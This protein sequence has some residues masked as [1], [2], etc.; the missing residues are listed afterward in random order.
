MT[1]CTHTVYVFIELLGISVT[2][3]PIEEQ[4]L[5]CIKVPLWT[6]TLPPN[7]PCETRDIKKGANNNNDNSKTSDKTQDRTGPSSCNIWTQVQSL[8]NSTSLLIGQVPLV[9][10]TLRYLRRL[11]GSLSDRM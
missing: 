3:F 2:E 5:N 11:S 10:L 4:M 8:K 1:N 9:K 7:A 6:K